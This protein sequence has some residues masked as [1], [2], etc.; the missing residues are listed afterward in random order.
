[1]S[2]FQLLQLSV[3][4]F[5][6]LKDGNVGVGV[7]PEDKEIL[8][9]GFRLCGIALQGVGASKLQMRQRTY[10]VADY[11][12]AMVENF[13]ELSG[14]FGALVRG[15]IGEATHINRIQ[16]TEKRIEV[17]CRYCQ[18]IRNGDL[19]QFDRLGRL[20]VVYGEECAKRW[21]VIELD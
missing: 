3:L 1:M 12:P 17:D 10:G 14:G 9:G 2:L 7:F 8:I 5:G 20:A 6:L 21:Q 18:L 19:Q 13:L 4:R 16:A 11:D 15:Q